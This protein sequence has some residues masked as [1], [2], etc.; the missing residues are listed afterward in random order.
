MR[1]LAIFLVL[2]GAALFFFT[3]GQMIRSF[4]VSAVGFILFL[5]VCAVVAFRMVCGAGLWL[6]WLMGGPPKR[7]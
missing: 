2:C 3:V 1:G 5:V 7:D 6:T 4:E